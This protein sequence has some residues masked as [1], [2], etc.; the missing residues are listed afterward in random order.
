MCLGLS[1]ETSALRG[2]TGLSSIRKM[3]VTWNRNLFLWKTKAIP[4]SSASPLCA[5]LDGLPVNKKTQFL[6]FLLMVFYTQEA[7][8]QSRARS[9]PTAIPP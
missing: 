1:R 7:R 6:T 5:E 8:R 9:C 2:E 4:A 3:R